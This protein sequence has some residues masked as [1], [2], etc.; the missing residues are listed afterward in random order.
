MNISY[1]QKSITIEEFKAIIERSGLHRQTDDQKKLQNM[2][3]NASILISAWDENTIVGYI[4]V[5][6]DYGDVA[7]VADLAV[8]KNYWNKGIGR[9]LMSELEAVLGDRIHIVLLA[10]ELAK[11]YY[12][13][14]GFSHDPRGYVK[15]PKNIS[16]SD[17][18]V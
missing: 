11:D 1:E 18:T 3:M 6:T 17:W 4:R 8:D 12:E 9:N 7:Y 10:S 5:L 13:K 14:I 15:V 16:P 2:L